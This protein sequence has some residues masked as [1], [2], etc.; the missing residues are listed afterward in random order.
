MGLILMLSGFALGFVSDRTLLRLRRTGYY[1]IPRGGFFN[2]VS[3]PHYLGELVEWCGF[4]IACN[5]SLASL[6]FVAWT[7]CNLIPRALAQHKWYQEKFK[8]DYPRER[9]AIIPFIL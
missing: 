4:C 2:M 7:A 3:M 9:M 8:E 1:H 5:F 6:S